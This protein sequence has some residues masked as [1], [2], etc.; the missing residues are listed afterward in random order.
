[1]IMPYIGSV[2][3]EES[4]Q[5]LASN[6]SFN[7]N[8]VWFKKLSIFSAIYLKIDSGKKILANSISDKG[9]IFRIYKELLQLNNKISLPN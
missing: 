7:K 8:C 6:L 9:L 3:N 5:K 1:M 2:I 4:Y